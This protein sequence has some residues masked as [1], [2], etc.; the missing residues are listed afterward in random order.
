MWSLFFVAHASPRH[1]LTRHGRSRERNLHP[2]GFHPIAV[3]A[4]LCEDTYP[5]HLPIQAESRAD[6][7]RRYL[8]SLV[9][10]SVPSV[11][12]LLVRQACPRYQARHVII[13]MRDGLWQLCHAAI[14]V[15]LSLLFLFTSNPMAGPCVKGTSHDVRGPL[16]NEN[17]FSFNTQ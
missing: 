1:D 11:V 7:P 12:C 2:I 9:N 5:S 13:S 14:Q 16:Q 15:T 3:V 17:F 4:R 6:W 8:L 10:S